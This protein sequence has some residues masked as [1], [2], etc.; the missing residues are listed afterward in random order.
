[1]VA[2][3]LLL[4][5]AGVYSAAAG[6]HK[7]LHQHTCWELVYVRTGQIGCP[8]GDAFYEGEPGVLLVTPPATPHTE[9]AHTA[10]SC[11]YCGIEAPV[12]LPW[13]RMC[14]DDP[15]STLAHLC[16]GL[17]REQRG[18]SPDSTE[19]LALL[20][21]QLS[22]HLRRAYER[23]Q[24]PSGERIVR[25]AEHFFHERLATSFTI[26]TV[27]RE[28]NVSPTV[29]RE[30]FRHARGQAPLARLHSLRVERAVVLIRTSDLTLEAIAQLCG[31]HS[32]SHLSRHVKRITGKSPGTFRAGEGTGMI[33]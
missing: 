25:D 24:L 5:F 16:M 17:I 30:H 21:Q 1:M 33:G 26:A 28:L 10:W 7:P 8:I 31:F 9:I 20:L 19:M 22:L 15:D 32:A 11:F 23:R 12:P 6:D 3:P 4:Q 14:R 18:H 29:L 2:S 27:A 13:P